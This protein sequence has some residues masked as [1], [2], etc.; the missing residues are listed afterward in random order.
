MEGRQ[1]RMTMWAVRKEIDQMLRDNK[2]HV[3]YRTTQE[4]SLDK[5]GLLAD[6]IGDVVYQLQMIYHGRAVVSRTPGG[7]VVHRI[8][9]REPIN[10]P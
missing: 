8:V 2:T 4:G 7:L 1:F 3:F 10:G 9:S 6:D 5:P